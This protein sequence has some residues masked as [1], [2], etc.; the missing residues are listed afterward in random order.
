[1]GQGAGSPEFQFYHESQRIDYRSEKLFI[2]LLV[3]IGAAVLFFVVIASAFFARPNT[4]SRVV[5]KSKLDT[6]TR[7]P[8]LNAFATADAAIS[9][10][11]GDRP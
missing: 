11:N 1:M 6:V 10:K 2:A 9:T 8:V 4:T 5:G 7:N 3:P